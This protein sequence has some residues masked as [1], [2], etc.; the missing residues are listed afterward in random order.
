MFLRLAT[1]A[2]KMGTHLRRVLGE[3][4]KGSGQY[5][6]HGLSH[7][8]LGMVASG[9]EAVVHLEVVVALAGGV[10]GLQ[11][12]EPRAVGVVVGRVP[13]IEYSEHDSS[14]IKNVA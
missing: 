2:I 11:R 8:G 1:H 6:V 3:K 7:L 10:V 14:A 5:V 13:L 9:H 12:L 4:G